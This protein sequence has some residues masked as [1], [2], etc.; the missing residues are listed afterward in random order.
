MN[1]RV[2]DTLRVFS[3]LATQV[4]WPELTRRF[5][6]STGAVIED[7]FGPTNALIPRIQA[8]ETADVAILIHRSAH[9]LQRAGVLTGCTD[10][11]SSYVGL[12]VKAGAAK[13][14][15]STPEALKAAL[16]AC[17]SIAYSRQGASGIYFVG[18]IQRLGIADAVNAK[19]IVIPLGFTGERVA[20]GETEL[21]VQQLSELKAVPGIDIVGP[22]PRSLQEPAVLTAAVF[23]R[24]SRIELARKLVAYLA[25]SEARP[26]LAASGLEPMG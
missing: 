4:A 3:T 7:V 6:L 5:K 22:I 26:I 20:N 10:I 24:S 9:E 12:A 17:R 14:D 8:G 23:T 1:T 2:P 11:A 13:P 18:L 25:S 16:L 21:A 15:I 19:A